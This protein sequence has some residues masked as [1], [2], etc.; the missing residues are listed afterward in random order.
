MTSPRAGQPAE[1]TEHRTGTALA[2]SAGEV[3]RASNALRKATR[4]A[5]HDPLAATE[6]GWRAPRAR[7]RRHVMRR[8]G[9][10]LDLN[11]D[12]RAPSLHGAMFTA[13]D[14]S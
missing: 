6:R 8:F 10:P 7:G 4:R 14:G 1:R 12:C 13:L 3:I 9:A 11:V 2:G 5:A